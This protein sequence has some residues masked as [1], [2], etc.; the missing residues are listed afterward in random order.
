MFCDDAVF[1]L[2]LQARRL[3][4]SH[5]NSHAR[6]FRDGPRNSLE[7]PLFLKAISISIQNVAELPSPRL[8]TLNQRDQYRMRN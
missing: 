7:L 3:V 5:A 6:A 8:V 1:I 2:R 4:E